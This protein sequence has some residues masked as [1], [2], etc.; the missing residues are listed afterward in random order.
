MA[1]LHLL[2]DVA[3][4]LELELLAAHFDHGLREES[5]TEAE[6][7]RE[8]V[9]AA[10]VECRSGR[11]LEPLEPRQEELRRARYAYL[12]R[13]ARQVA[14]TRI[15]T[16]HQADDQA[17]TILFRILRGTGIRG[18]R[19]IPERRG[20][21]VRPLLPFGRRV[22][23][24]Y[25]RERDIPFIVDPSNLDPRWERARLRARVL[26]ALEES[27]E[28]P[29][30]ERLLELGRAARRAERALQSRARFLLAQSQ[31]QLTAPDGWREDARALDLDRLRGL[32]REELAR[33]IRR[34]AREAG[35]RLTKGGT[36]AAVEF[37]SEGR[38]GGR[39]DIGGGLVAAREFGVVWLGRPTEAGPD[40]TL[41]IRGPEPGRGRVSL[42]GRPVVVAW[43]SGREPTV[44]RAPVELALERIA[45]PLVVRSWRA[46][47]R[48]RTDAGSRKL[49][50]LFG[51]RRIPK[52]GR[53]QVPVVA[54]RE[55]QVV[56]VGSLVVD[57]GLRPDAGEERLVLRIEDA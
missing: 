23:E 48:I 18:L 4:D 28:G 30:R 11:P 54:S 16:G 7:V 43:E 56:A 25:L 35:A 27:W 8:W 31:L 6:S 38:S 13:V 24:R 53:R 37:I 29:V 51:E 47:D 19:G 3:G 5:A 41:T 1:L 49:K 26:P 39:V 40:T 2:L 57:P 45:F 44:L 32:D 36:R 50:K 14:A 9:A 21:I 20:P 52:S 12:R 22:L 55:G 42:G 33:V 17:E 46:G 10:G 34:A 15:A